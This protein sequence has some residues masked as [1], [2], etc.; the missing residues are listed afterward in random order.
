MPYICK[1]VG[2]KYELQKKD[3]TK[4]FGTHPSKRACMKQMKAIYASELNNSDN[5]RFD[6]F[7][8]VPYD[9]EA[10]LQNAK[11]QID[12]VVNSRGGS[13]FDAL[14]IH[15]KLRNS[16]KKIVGHVEG[17]AFS[18]GALLLLACDEVYMP[19]NA[20]L[21]FH[22]PR[23]RLNSD[24]DQKA[25]NLEQ[26]A[27]ALRVHENIVV[28]TLVSKTK[29]S[30]D[31]CRAMLEK[32]TYLTAKEALELG[33]VTEIVPIFQ[34]YKVENSLLPERI[35]TFVNECKA[36]NSKM[37]LKDVCEQ[38]G[39]PDSEEGLIEFIKKLQTSQP[40]TKA[41]VNKSIVNM[42]KQ[43]REAEL[44]TLVNEGVAVPAMVND[45]KVEFLNDTRIEE[46]T[47]LEDPN[48]LFLTVVNAAKK[49]DKV[50]S[51]QGKSGTQQLG[52]PLDKDEP[53][54]DANLL[55]TL[56]KKDKE[57]ERYAIED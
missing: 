43:F 7:V 26:L 1:A 9:F 4:T 47:Q 6:G 41:P 36:E 35:V 39:L 55:V 51:F 40:K 56:M 42:V 57:T 44:N 13:L 48:K 52:N 31:E 16:G 37:A 19:E 33:I 28:S 32:E 8:S 2:T 29:K 18:A 38:F 53:D 11:D 23:A 27:A 20:L 15:N 34:D 24:T 30:E 45:L 49:N 12:I 10:R 22:M 21:M 25:E 50:I 46:D 3:G 5:I 17:I 14:I 54:K